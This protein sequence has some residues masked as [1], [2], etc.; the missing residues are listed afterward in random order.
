ME[1][2]RQESRANLSAYRHVLDALGLDIV[3][4]SVQEGQTLPNVEELAERF[5]VSRTVLREVTRVLSSKG[6]LRPRQGVG[7]IVLPRSNWMLLDEDV[8]TWIGEVGLDDQFLEE[9]DVVRRMIEP[10]AAA[11]A[12]EMATARDIDSLQAALDGMAQTL[13]DP[14][15]Y[16]A[17]DVDFHRGVM[18]ATHNEILSNLTNAVILAMRVRHAAAMRRTSPESGR[19]EEHAAIL[20]AIKLRR[21]SDASEAVLV[22]LQATTEDDRKLRARRKKQSKVS[23][24]GSTST[25]ARAATRSR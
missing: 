12:A 17:F 7:A 18:A 4:G 8:L 20:D 5:D 23:I 2:I 13:G 6:L 19:F 1:A 14:E 16:V 24:A 21:P 15:A 11:I 22:L 9:L 10:P 3:S 25:S